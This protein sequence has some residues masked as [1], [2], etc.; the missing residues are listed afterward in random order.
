VAE[1]VVA[2]LASLRVACRR[3]AYH[4]NR[5]A[6]YMAR[7]DTGK[8]REGAQ[9]AGARAEVVRVARCVAWRHTELHAACRRLT[10]VRVSGRRAPGDM[11]AS[12]HLEGLDH[13]AEDILVCAC[14]CVGRRDPHACDTP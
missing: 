1:R 10:G 6:A 3:A 11:D 7:A 4:A 8:L 5:A 13:G 14:V 12:G 9:C 2:R